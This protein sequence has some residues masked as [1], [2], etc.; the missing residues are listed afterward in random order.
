MHAELGCVFFVDCKPCVDAFHDG[1]EACHADNK[2]PARVHAVMHVALDDVPKQ[3][4][5]WMPAHLKPGSC[6]AAIRGDGFLVEESDVEA[7]DAAD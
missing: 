4:V 3:A 6:G 2:P 5:I 7:N 1:P